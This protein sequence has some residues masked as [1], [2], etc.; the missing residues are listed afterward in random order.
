MYNYHMK[1]NTFVY[2]AERNSLRNSEYNNTFRRLTIKFIYYNDVALYGPQ[3]RRETTT[4]NLCSRHE[5]TC[6]LHSFLYV[7]P[8]DPHT[9]SL[10]CVNVIPALVI[11]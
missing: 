2:V 5:V 1:Q 11:G 9:S 3:G 6:K 7:T 8:S 4:M 10:I